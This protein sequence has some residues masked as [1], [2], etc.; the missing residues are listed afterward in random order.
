MPMC[1]FIYTVVPT[2]IKQVTI[3]DGL[4]FGKPATLECNV[5]TLVSL[6]KIISRVDF[7]WAIFFFSIKK[8]VEN[9]TANI[10]NNSAI[11]TDRLVTPP[12]GYFDVGILYSCQVII[13]TASGVV[14]NNSRGIFLDFPGK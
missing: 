7:V 13:H 9:V 1:I 11:Y 6:R 5:V 3:I 12:L 2:P 4:Q 14:Y 10:V 8:K